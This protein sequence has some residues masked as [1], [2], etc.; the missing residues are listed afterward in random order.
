MTSFEYDVIH[1]QHPDPISSIAIILLK[2]VNKK[3]K[4]L[5]TWHAEIYKTYK[6]FSPILLIIDLFLFSISNKIIYFTPFHVGSSFL[7]RFNFFKN[8]IRIIEFSIKKPKFSSQKIKDRQLTNIT[9]K[10]NID[11]LSVGRLVSYKGYEYSISAMQEVDKRVRY[12]IIGSGTLEIKLRELINNLK[13]SDRVFLLGSLNE[14]EKDFYFFKSDLF[15]FP[16]INQSEAFGIAQL[17]ALSFGLPIINTQLHN[18]VNYLVPKNIAETCRHS[19]SQELANA[20]N[21]IINNNDRYRDLTRKSYIHFQNYSISNMINK[22]K[23][24]LEEI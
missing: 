8:K 9:K 2:I 3:V 10:R 19:N 11:L 6:I 5:T 23:L 1:I 22:Y 14:E 12:F 24:L 4:I 15:I 13:L 16:S 18:G 7:A 20:I 21:K 17:E